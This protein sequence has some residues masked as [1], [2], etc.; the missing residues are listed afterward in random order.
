[1]TPQEYQNKALTT[2]VTD[3]K[4]DTLIMCTLGLSGETG[5][6]TDIIKKYLFHKN[7]NQLNINKLKDELGD[8]LWYLSVLSSTVNLTLDE[9]MENNITKL[10]NR[11][12]N[13]F[14]PKYASDSGDSL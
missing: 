5:E 12:G 10:A 14:N 6:I 13:N 2:I 1:M 7:G 11:H 4:R 3:N 8:V 9:I